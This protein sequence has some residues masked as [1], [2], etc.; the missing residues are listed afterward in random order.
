[1][2]HGRRSIDPTERVIESP[3]FF[4]GGRVERIDLR[5]ATTGVNG[6]VNHRRRRLEADLIMDQ[7]I[8]AAME[9][10]FLFAGLRINGVKIT[11][12]TAHKHH[13]VYKCGRSVHDIVRFEFPAQIASR[14]I[15]RIEI[16][17]AASKINRAVRHYRARQ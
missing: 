17:I 4:P 6:S 13:A 3:L 5:I 7:R 16:A 8:F 14:R 12:P 9:T 10:P 15:Q 1:L 2:R 11:V